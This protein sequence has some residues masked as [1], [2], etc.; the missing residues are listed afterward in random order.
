[1]SINPNSW[2]DAQTFLAVLESE[3]FSKAA[4]QLG[5]G[6]PTVSRRIQALEA[7]L[8][9]QIFERGKYGATP[10]PAALRLQPAAEQMAKW[11]AEFQRLAEGVEDKL[12]GTIKIAAPPGVA[13]EQLAP[14]AGKLAALEPGLQL[15][16]LSAVEHVDLSRG[17][18]DLAIRSQ[19]PNEPELQCLHEAVAKPGVY[20]AKSY[21]EKIKQPCRWQDLDWICWG[22]QHKHLA[23]RSLLERVIPNF[24]LVFASDDYIV[25]KAAAASG[26]GALITNAPLGFESIELVKIDVGLELPEVKFYLVCAK[27][28]RHLKKIKV[29]AKHLLEALDTELG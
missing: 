11:A 23:P 20:A 5:V 10:T 28:M 19:P 6:Q 7:R 22:G 18:A 15:E 9:S 24:Q 27:S 2:E 21:A 26:V 29:V 25:Q 1:M 3:S 14:F 8:E 16:V 17:Y 12:T 13:A 4:E